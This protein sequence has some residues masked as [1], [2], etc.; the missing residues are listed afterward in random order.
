M[1]VHS[2][3]IGMRRLRCQ[4]KRTIFDASKPITERPPTR[5]W[6]PLHQKSFERYHKLRLNCG[7]WGCVGDWSRSHGVV[8]PAD[9]AKVDRVRENWVPRS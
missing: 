3:N 9:F 1:Y 4:A 8:T 2:V 5:S 6:N 7:R